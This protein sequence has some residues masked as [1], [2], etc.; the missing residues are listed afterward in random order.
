MLFIKIRKNITKRAKLWPLV[1][2]APLLVH[3]GALAAPYGSGTYGECLYSQGCSTTSQPST[4]KSTETPGTILLNDY[5]DYFTDSGVTLDLKAKQVVYYDVTD[6]NGTTRYKITIKFIDGNGIVVT[7]SP[8]GQ[9]ITLGIGDSFK[10]DANGD[11]QND[12][13]ITLDNINGTKASINFKDL[14][15]G[16]NIQP[17]S[18]NATTGHNWPLIIVSIILVL[19]GLIWFIIILFKR[20]R[21]DDDD[22]PSSSGTL[23]TP[24]RP[25]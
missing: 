12:I 3:T 10:Y 1:L 24:N 13:Q 18:V 21:Q 9:D 11:G 4:H 8:N 7:L 19:L 14:S 5:S 16:T 22:K 25:T 17:P 15:V 20:R 23:F 6:D 2:L